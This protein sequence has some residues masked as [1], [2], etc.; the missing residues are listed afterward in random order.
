MT[1][2]TV[3][4]TL[5]LNPAKSNIILF[6][7]TMNIDDAN[8]PPVCLSSGQITYVDKVV[9]LGLLGPCDIACRGILVSF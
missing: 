6:R 2:W 4:N 1:Y 7:L 5:C 3:E 9:N 8:L